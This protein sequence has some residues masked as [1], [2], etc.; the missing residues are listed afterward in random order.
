MNFFVEKYVHI[1]TDYY[2]FSYKVATNIFLPK[3]LRHMHAS[4]QNCCIS[5]A[6]GYFSKCLPKDFYQKVI[7]REKTLRGK[8][9]NFNIFF[10]LSYFL[11]FSSFNVSEDSGTE[12]WNREDEIQSPDDDIS[13]SDGDENPYSNFYN[14]SFSNMFFI[15][16]YL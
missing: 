11:V 12:F 3:K 15:V 6:I 13:D 16:L 5:G 9:S 8:N 7:T 4:K 14:I 10:C 1:V 2:A